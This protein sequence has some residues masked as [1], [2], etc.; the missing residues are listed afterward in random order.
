[1]FHFDVS[2]DKK[3]Q[4]REDASARGLD[5]KHMTISNANADGVTH[6]IPNYLKV[7]LGNL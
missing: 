6:I 3:Q 5:L 7:S 2:G 4:S 1:M